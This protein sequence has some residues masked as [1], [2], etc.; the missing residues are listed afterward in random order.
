MAMRRIYAWYQQEMIDRPPIRFTAHNAEFTAPHLL[1][2][3]SWPDLK[4]R[5]F[6]AEFQVDFF[7][8]SIKGHTFHAETFPVFWPNL[9]PEIFVAFHGSELIFK[10]V[11]S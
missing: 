11:T 9:G 5:W 6:D 10:D 8:E 4:A 7:I 3:R 2:R 1:D